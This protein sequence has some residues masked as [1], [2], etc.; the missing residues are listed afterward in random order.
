MNVEV[1]P[2]I[3]RLSLGICNFYLIDGGGKLILVD[4]GTPSDWKLLAQAVAQLGREIDDLEAILLTHAHADHTGFAERAR[5]E[6][7]STVWIHRRDADVARSGKVGK[8]EGRLT[9][10]LL[11]GEFY[12][13]VFSLAR[14]GGAKIIPIHE[15][16]TFDDGQELDLPGSP[17]VVHTP[18]HTAGSACIVLAERRVLL[19]GDALVTRNPLTGRV[20]PQVMPSAFNADTG[21][22]M[23]SLARVQALEADTVLTGHGEPWT[24]GIAAAVAAARAAGPS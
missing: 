11:H 23:R 13:T 4:A 22:A 6:A 16:S 10:Y 9:S 5:T 3:R 20:G 19:T 1:M 21:Q 2:G 7:A 8:S 15:V 18:G 17:R 14:R 12:R 24:D